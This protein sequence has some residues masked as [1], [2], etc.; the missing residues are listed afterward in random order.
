MHSREKIVLCALDLA[1][2]NGWDSVTLADIAEHCKIPLS[3]LYDSVE[4]KADILTAFGRMID[5]KVMENFSVDGESA[6]DNLFD[7]LMERFDA[8]NEHR[9]GLSSILESFKCDPKQL[10]IGMP[11]VCRSMSWMLEACGISTSGIKG[12]VRVAGLSGLYL[13][14][15]RVWLK[16]NTADMAKV[17]A[18]L[19][20]DLERAER[21]AGFLG[22]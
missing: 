1:A 14:T 7:I 19:D 12:A 17:M 3:D 9:E 18:A 13:K 8:L 6:R 16:D 10:V 5:K 15:L 4:D 22:Q 21:W 11:H 2:K 20:R